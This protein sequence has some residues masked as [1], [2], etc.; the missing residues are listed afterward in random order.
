MVVPPTAQQRKGI[1]PVVTLRANGGELAEVAVGEAV[2]FTASIEVPPGAG[3]V[4]QAAWD[5]EGTGAFPV[6]VQLDETNS[7][8]ALLNLNATYHFSRPG[9]YFPVVQAAS[10]RHGDKKTNLAQIRNLNRVRVV[11][12]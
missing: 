11:V 12:R 6:V 9:T 3:L 1:Q 4:S 7:G 2:A 5:F 10:Q 8:H